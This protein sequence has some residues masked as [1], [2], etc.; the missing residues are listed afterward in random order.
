MR[1]SQKLKRQKKRK[2]V[3]RQSVDLQHV[4]MDL[5]PGPGPGNDAASPTRRKR[6][7]LFGEKNVQRKL[8]RNL[9]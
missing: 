6:R 8:N 4:L 7:N 3:K 1:L 2:A 5:F 9:H